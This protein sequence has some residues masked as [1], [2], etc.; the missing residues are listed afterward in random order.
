MALGRGANVGSVF[1]DVN[2]NAENF[3][4]GMQ[5]AKNEAQRSGAAMSSALDKTSASAKN[6]NGSLT[7][8][9]SI[10]ATIGGISLGVQIIKMA[11]S[12]TQMRGRLALVVKE[13]ENLID[14]EERLYE[15]AIRNR[16]ALEPTVSLYTRLRSARADLSD[17]QALKIVDTWNKTLVVSG[18]SSQGAAASTTQFSQ[19][20][21]SGVL[22]AEEFN[23]IVENNVRA[24]Q[25]F[26]TSLG[27]SVGE[28]RGLVNEGKVGFDELVKALTADAGSVATEFDSM[29]MTVG[30][31]MTNLDSAIVRFIG[32]SD[33]GAGS[34]AQ[35]AKWISIVADNLDTLARALMAAGV[36]ISAAFSIGAVL[37][38]VNAIGALVVAIRTAT[39]AA[40]GFRAVMAFLGGPWGMALFAA[41]AVIYE[42]TKAMEDNR[43]ASEKA[44]EAAKGVADQIKATDDIIAA[45]NLDAAT[46]ALEG[47]G[48]EAEKTAA[49][50]AL[51]AENM[52]K[53][54]VAQKQLAIDQQWEKN[55][56]LI[57]A[58]ADLEK[59][60][61]NPT[62]RVFVERGMSFDA[63]RF[64]PSEI[65]AKRKELEA[66]KAQL[67][68]GEKRGQQLLEVS[69]ELF[70]PDT[71]SR[72][73]TDD[74]KDTKK[75][76]QELTG[77]YTDLERLERNLADIRAAEK[78]GATGASRAAVQAMLDYL[79]ATGDVATVLQTVANLQGNILSD[80]DKSIVA[81]FVTASQLKKRMDAPG[82]K[83]IG[84]LS[85][86]NE[87]G[88]K[89]PEPTASE[90]AWSTYEQR[91]SDATKQGLMQAIETGD[92]GDS[93]RQILNDSLREALSSAM[94]VLFDAISQIDW[95]GSGKGWGGFFNMIGGAF[96]GSPAGGKASGG[97]VSAGRKYR[98]GEQ[99]SEWFVPNTDGFIIPNRAG[100][101]MAGQSLRAMSPIA[102]GGAVININGNVGP[103][104]VDQMRSALDAFGRRLPQMIDARVQ[105]RQKR[106]AY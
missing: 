66:L 42:L 92:W 43:S 19:A 29:S 93:L 39:T 55:F 97:P 88:G 89:D 13:S 71:P 68:A 78:E 22:R 65:A 90:Q 47:M 52:M 73:A 45:S 106:G 21:A 80:A 63:P 79:D 2:A 76:I 31:A 81:G 46:K 99:G 82:N 58:I 25:L 51:L 49:K 96:G 94:D 4:A 33:Q 100:G 5:R 16:A 36:G 91:V 70:K 48:T 69:A 77:Y 54:G 104:E 67:A 24:V 32:L 23:S 26:A 50:F 74:A 102:V 15:L 7:N 60:I 14:V 37:S 3:H 8:L 53:T 105:D 103:S 72:S 85:G 57:N 34:S 6:L 75:T 1:I 101:A 12:F 61:A 20:M 11:D 40:I 30:Q 41:V 28:L 59:E 17:D 56:H 86:V 44:A 83:P 10:L 87:I 35:L 18:A 38:L 27:V 9:R 95:G 84:D 64:S 98:V 62:E